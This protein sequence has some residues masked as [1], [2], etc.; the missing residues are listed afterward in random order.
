MCPRLHLKNVLF[1]L[2]NSLMYYSISYSDLVLPKLFLYFLN[3]QDDVA[4][5]TMK[6]SRRSDSMM[7]DQFSTEFQ[8]PTVLI[9]RA[10]HSHPKQVNAPYPNYRMPHGDMDRW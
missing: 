7:D 9:P 6:R 5:S 4:N 1:F 8:V 2:K 3:L 10:K